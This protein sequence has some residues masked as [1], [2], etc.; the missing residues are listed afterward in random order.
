[1][2]SISIPPKE[3][4][5]IINGDLVKFKNVGGTGQSTYMHAYFY[6]EQSVDVPLGTTKIVLHPDFTLTDKWW[7]LA[8]CESTLKLTSG[9]LSKFSARW[10]SVMQ[11]SFEMDWDP[12]AIVF[13]RESGI[14][15]VKLLLRSLYQ[16][17]PAHARWAKPE[18]I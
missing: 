11:L 18:D 6:T 7:P 13:E 17:N 10:N 8:G 1:M 2:E 9:I 5:L 4:T 15:Y 16:I 12:T 14:V 3:S